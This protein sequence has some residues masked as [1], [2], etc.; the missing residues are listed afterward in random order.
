MIAAEER[1]S[2]PVPRWAVHALFLALD[3]VVIGSATA[4]AYWL[5][6]EGAVPERFAD[7]ALITLVSACVVFP[8][9]FWLLRLY[10]HLWRHA[11]T[12]VVLKL[13]TGTVAAT[14]LLLGADVLVRAPSGSRYAPVGVL[15]MIG[16]LTLLGS[17]A[18][19]M[20]SRTLA[21]VQSRTPDPD[22]LRVL[23][24]G[25]GD[26]GSLL[27]RDIDSRPELGMRVIG[28]L[29]DDRGKLGGVV[30]GV[31]VLGPSSALADVVTSE[32]VDEV[33]V[34]MPGATRD[35]RREVVDA[36]AR[37]GVTTRLVRLFAGEAEN[38]GV[39]DLQEVTVEDLLGR[40]PVE[41]D[42]AGIAATIAGRCVAVTGAAGSIGSE[43]CR[44]VL[45]LAP[46]RLV[47]LD[48]DESRLYE[49]FLE[50]RRDGA[51]SPEMRI[52]DVRDPGKI[53]RLLAEV[54]PEIVLHAAAYKHVPLMELEPD[55]AVRANVEGTRNVLRACESAGV[56]HF[57]LISTDKAVH[58]TSVMGATKAIAE[59]LAF[60]A[61]ARGR[62]RV[63]VV[64][65]G[66]VLA[67]RGSVVPLFERQL[68]DGGPIT[69]THPE[70]TR[71]F[72]TIPEAARLVLQAQAIGGGGDLFVL[73]M[74]EPVP[75]VDLARK[76]IT[77]SGAHAEIV[78][79]G[80]RPAEKL[81]EVLAHDDAG[82]S[83]TGHEKVLR[84]DA[85][86]V[87]PEGLDAAVDAL[88]AAARSG[89][90]DAVRARL[91]ETAPGYAPEAAGD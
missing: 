74:G 51:E 27:L 71:Y 63:S 55:E 53:T 80:L 20:L 57:V 39:A 46:A 29:D 1:R 78:F 62:L 16:V 82:L 23:I 77:L 88:V 44:Q 43:L 65:F 69:V 50:L 31:R 13:V 6:F 64:R 90:A 35:A 11:G 66:N 10:H 49:L 8:V 28:F 79:T 14:A 5:R 7:T 45:A 33:V 86:P 26:A 85:P 18:V 34:A 76:M 84:A 24:V 40:E 70:V 67:S 38:V 52:C 87:P 30:G 15:I 54:R 48:I 60:A 68:R 12:D 56:K 41:I 19:R 3:L 42:S 83:P 21:Y 4:T 73:E 59:L 47:L 72:M 2:L 81:H 89:D 61:A 17:G 22:A 9:A 37:L 58:P 91:L 25:A 75:I 32:R 36:C